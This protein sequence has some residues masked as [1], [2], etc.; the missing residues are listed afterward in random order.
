MTPFKSI[1]AATDFSADGQYAVRRAALL[2]HE[3]GARLHILHV[4]EVT[5]CRRLREWFTPTM[6][7]D[8]K[9]AQARAALR[10][11]A[12]ELLRAYDVDA[13]VEVDI[14][15]PF[16]ALLRASQRADLVVVGRR[17][18]SRFS[19]LLM[20]RTSDRLLRTCQRPVLAVRTAADHPYR[21]V[22][23]PIDFTSSSDAAIQAAAHIRGAAST[24]AFHA[25]DSRRD[26]LLRDADVPEHV[27]REA[28]LMEEERVNARMRRK[29]DGLG[30]EGTAV[31]FALAYGPAARATL[32]QAQQRRA[33]LIVA[34]RQ[35]RSML[36][37]LLRGS[38]SGRVLSEAVCDV[39]IVPNLRVSALPR[40]VE[41]AAPQR[42]AP[43]PSGRAGDAR[44]GAALAGIA[45][46]RPW[47][48]NTP[49]FVSRTERPS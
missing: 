12:V 7:V 34:G 2:A 19:A 40:A 37:G 29:V 11:T 33:D 45:T 21:R 44:S 23:L 36:G 9:A 41:K 3:H 6:H 49:R 1:L 42:D 32:H 15:D 24:Q 20:G 25:I 16:T 46:R 39:L 18:Y 8:Q 13:T 47:I 31:S 17:R 5:R 22:L 10:R 43:A 30:L 35:D 26:A 27:I 48:H 38:V 28:R 4:L 14:G